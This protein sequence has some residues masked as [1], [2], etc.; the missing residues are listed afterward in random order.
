MQELKKEDYYKLGS[1]LDSETFNIEAKSVVQ[2]NNPGRVFVDDATF[3]KEGLIWSKGIEG[4]YF[5]AEDVHRANQDDLEHSIEN[6]ILP[7]CRKLNYK[8]LEISCISPAHNI[9]IKRVLSKRKLT[10]WKQCVYG[11][12]KEMSDLSS[13]VVDEPAGVY[14]IDKYFLEN[15]EAQN[16]DFVLKPLELCW[17]HTDNF[18]KKGIG[19]CIM[20]DNDIAS[21]CYSG[22]VSG[23][24]HVIN[25]ETVEKYRRKGLG[26]LLTR[27]ILADYLSKNIQPYWD[28]TADNTAS[29]MLA[30]KVGFVKSFEYTCFGI[31]VN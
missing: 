27:T 22:F 5:F 16:K 18:I 23:N 9:M 10:S 17:D 25:I 4:F 21:I 12:K 6:N 26:E 8:W 2:L 7:L 30:E 29:C 1:L 15:T 24:T 11:Y 13:S 20:V 19:Y 14:K 3:P 31:P 28:C